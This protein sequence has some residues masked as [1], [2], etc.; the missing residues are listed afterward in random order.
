MLTLVMNDGGRYRGLICKL[1]GSLSGFIPATCRNCAVSP[2]PFK[3]TIHVELNLQMILWNAAR[4]VFAST[5]VGNF[6]A[7]LI[8]RRSQSVDR[9]N[10]NE[11]APLV[12]FSLAT[13]QRDEI[14][15]NYLTEELVQYHL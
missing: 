15:N 8:C 7:F 3:M 13:I 9:F 10:V 14:L 1:N 12:S 6:P 11:L 4:N 5:N 2:I